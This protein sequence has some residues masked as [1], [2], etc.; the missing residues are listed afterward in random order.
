M[1][2]PI[3]SKTEPIGGRDIVRKTLTVR[4]QRARDDSALRGSLQTGAPLPIYLVS[5]EEI[6]GADP[7]SSAKIVGWRYPVIGGASAGLV[8]LVE[9]KG[10]LKFA[11]VSQG[12]LPARLLEA[13]ALAEDNLRS[14]EER[15]EP[16]LLEIPSLRVTALWLCGSQGQNLFIFLVDGQR[17]DSSQLQIEHS[18]QPRVTAALT[19]LGRRSGGVSSPP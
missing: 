11:G 18:V 3:V 2:M 9:D 7:L 17:W 12:L 16:R 6:S 4:S 13:A 10:D 14:T 1:G 19:A 15:L 8:T 5:S